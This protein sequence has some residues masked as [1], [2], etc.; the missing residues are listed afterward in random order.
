[1]IT[2]LYIRNI[3]VVKELNIDF[4][5]GFSTL[6]GETG[7]GKSV[8]MDCIGILL[9]SRPIKG[10]IRHGEREALIRATFETV[11]E[12]VQSKL[13]E[14]GF[15]N[16]DSLILQ[17]SFNVD[18][19]TVVKLNGQTVTQSIAKDIASNLISIHGQN[20][21]QKLMQKSEHLNVLD[22][23]ANLSSFRDDYSV[24]YNSYKSLTDKLTE[25]KNLDKERAR[26]YDVYQFQ[27]NEIDEVNP[28]VGEEEKLLSEEK[29]LSNIE[30]IQKHSNFTYHVLQGSERS[31]TALLDKASSSLAHLRDCVP[32]TNELNEKL[33]Q[34]RYEISD[35]ADTIND[36]GQD[37]GEN[38]DKLLDKIGSRLNAISRLKK[39]YGNTIDE[40]LVFRKELGTKIADMENSEYL[41]EQTEAE[42]AKVSQELNSKALLLSEA[43]KKAAIE[44]Q[45]KIMNQLEFLEMPKVRFVI[46]FKDSPVPL[47]TGKDV[48]EFLISTNAGQLPMPMAKIASGGEL[49]RIMLAI[50]SIL[51]DKDGVKSV[52]FDE[53]DT[54]IS[55]KTSRKVGIKLKEIAKHV[56]VL[57][58]THSAQIASLA[59]NHYLVSK[60]EVNGATQTTLQLLD[61]DARINEVARILGGLNVTQ[62]QILAAEEMINEGKRL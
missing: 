38:A 45:D 43:R 24:T 34:I 49:S 46:D 36:F 35:I 14:F 6:T 26:L 52:I 11:P 23:F 28:K 41:I 57:C 22:W 12:E 58:V 21:N 53:I 15:E 16:E 62:N 1:M 37:N 31:V 44:L 40:I 30:K 33:I 10:K 56:Q 13:V 54:G 2:S 17:R 8:I 42:L 3:A 25:L 47:S 50:K 20:D 59:D 32:Q 60:S 29:R 51:L 39:K 5:N 48:V 4:S 55:G 7:A 27:A 9:G 19:K 61:N 18:G